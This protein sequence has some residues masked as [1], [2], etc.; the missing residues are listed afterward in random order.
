MEYLSLQLYK[1]TQLLLF[2]V[3]FEKFGGAIIMSRPNPEFIWVVRFFNVDRLLRI[4][5]YVRKFF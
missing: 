3:N 1:S 4:V 2:S 5:Q